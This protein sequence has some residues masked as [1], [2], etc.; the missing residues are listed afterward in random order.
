MNDVISILDRYEGSF[1]V[2]S[3]KD[4]RGKKPVYEFIDSLNTKTA[5]KVVRVIGLLKEHGPFLKRPFA[6]KV[7]GDIYEL[8]IHFS[9]SQIR[10]LYAFCGKGNIVLLHGF[11][12]KSNQIPSEELIKANHRLSDWKSR[13]DQG[14]IEL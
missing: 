7:E 10:I 8:R 12:K 2:F 5:A 9:D 11:R 6:D 13:C 14:V 1:R 4:A 3:Y